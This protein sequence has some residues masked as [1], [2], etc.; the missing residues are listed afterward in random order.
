MNYRKEV[1][2]EAGSIEHGLGMPILN[3]AIFL[4]IAWLFITGVLIKGIRSSGKASYFLALFPYVIILI[5]LVR[6][7]TLPGA[8]NGILFFI[9]PR[10]D[11]ILEPSVSKK[12]QIVDRKIHSI[13]QFRFGMRPLYNASSPW[14]LDSAIS[15]CI[16]RSI[17]STTMFIAMLRSSRH[18]THSHRCWPAVPFSVFWVIW[19]MKWAPKTS[20]R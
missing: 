12:T 10:W 18:W 17:S 9:R 4:L 16:H 13:V 6:A 14:P 5:L 2:Q 3:L 1:L 20:L 19:H 15:L 8:W 11:M 7:V